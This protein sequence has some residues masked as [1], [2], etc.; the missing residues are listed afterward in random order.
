M[1]T[2]SNILKILAVLAIIAGIIYVVINYGDKI[3][4]WFKKVLHICPCKN[5]CDECACEGDCLDCDCD[6]CECDHDEILVA[7]E[8]DFEG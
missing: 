1:K 3:V 4:A 7:S 6:G 8:S 5:D 2:I